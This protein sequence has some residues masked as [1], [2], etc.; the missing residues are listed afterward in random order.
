MPAKNSR[1]NILMFMPD[2]LR[3]DAIGAFGNTRAH[4]PNIDALAAR[5]TR[6]SNAFAQHPVCGPSRC[7][8]MTGWYPH[9]RGHR[10]LT[11]LLKPDEPNLLR[12]LKDAGYHVAWAG[13]RG[14]TFAPGVVEESTHFYGFDRAPEM[15]FEFSN[16]PREDISAR[17]FYHGR[18]LRQSSA[19]T[20]C[21]DFDEAAV[22]TAE[23]LLSEGMPE[24]WILLIAL[25]FPHPP[26]EV[27][28]PWINLHNPDDM[29][30]PI[31]R[32]SG[33]EPK[34]MEALRTSYATDRASPEHWRQIASV[35]HGMTSR[36]DSQLGRVLAAVES[37]GMTDNTA[38][39]FF[40][41]HGEY[42]GDYGLIEKWP[43]G[44]EDCLLR[45]PLIISPPGG[46]EAQEATA[47]VELLDLLPT[48]LDWAG[49]EAEHTHFG[50]SLLPL[51]DNPQLAHKPFAVS[52][53]GFTLAEG[54]LLEKS[55]FPYDLKA[56]VQADDISNVGRA[57]ALRTPRWTYVH[58]LYDCDEL[59]D[60]IAD[61]RETANL[62]ED[63][64]Y[65]PLIQELRDQLLDFMTGTAD[66]I[67][68]QTDPRF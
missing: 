6:F 53:G 10:T 64:R 2:Q 13:R 26:F 30:A 15:L 61:P 27:E 67:P 20:P 14:D 54:N 63:P 68:W 5:G 25:I 58:R 57:T 60:R 4:T 8:F 50:S 32:I 65:Q 31:Q 21:F 52:E 59:Y 42:L 35:Y 36:V 48:C 16:K 51:L 62:I 55:A 43:A 45:N 19:E 33:P 3:A 49:S 1:P 7:S 17:T 22:C 18:R 28:Q 56:Q 37:A 46:S 23:R 66:V 24:P 9:V 40:T 12:L 44:L 38:T 29:P 34:Y 39:I 41:D 11:H 47:M